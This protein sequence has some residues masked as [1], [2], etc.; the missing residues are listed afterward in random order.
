MGAHLVEQFREVLHFRLVGSIFED[1]NA[2]GE[3]SGHHEIL[4]AGYGNGVELEIRAPQSI[5]PGIH[6]AMVKTDGGP[7]FLQS[8]EMKVDGTN[9]NRAAAWQR[10]SRLPEAR[11]Q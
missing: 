10:D 8:L 2:L 9:A 1:R 7:K 5:G 3:R 6:V 11:H 4:G